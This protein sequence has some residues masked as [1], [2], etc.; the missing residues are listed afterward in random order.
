M[1]TGKHSCELKYE[2]GV[3]VDMRESVL[4]PIIRGN[5]HTNCSYSFFSPGEN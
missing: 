4:R 3:N 5:V 1:G 2:I